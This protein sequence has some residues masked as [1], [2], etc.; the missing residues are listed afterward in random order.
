MLVLDLNEFKPQERKICLSDKEF[1]LTFIPFEISIQYYDLLPAMQAMSENKKIEISDFEKV[2]ELIY[3]MFKISVPD[4][5]KEWLRKEI[6][7]ARM[8]KLLPY[9][10][11]AIFD[12]GKKKEPIQTQIEE[13][14]QESI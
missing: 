8:I 1:D 5:D 9:L 12:D 13:P 4:L 14:C 7:F 10:S 2:F 6:N 11:E 3:S